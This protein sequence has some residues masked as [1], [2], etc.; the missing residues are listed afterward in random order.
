MKRTIAGLIAGLVLGV[1]GTAGAMT[2]AYWEGKGPTYTCSGVSS[3][4]SCHERYG[5]Y[6]IYIT[7]DFV[8]ITRGKKDKAVYGCR[9][10]WA[11]PAQACFSG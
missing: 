9:R 5:Q 6:G 8:A 10:G 1:A 4:A 11:S 7:R 3:G 2:S